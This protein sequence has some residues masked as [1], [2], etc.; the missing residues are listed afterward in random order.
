MVETI[1][2]KNGNFP[3]C[4]WAW[5]ST[6]GWKVSSNPT[7][8]TC[9]NCKR[10]GVYKDALKTTPVKTTISNTTTEEQTKEETNMSTVAYNV[11][12]NTLT[13]LINGKLYSMNTSCPE[14]QNAYD[15][16][17]ETPVDAEALLRVF[18][19]VHAVAGY[20]EGDVKVEGNTITYKGRAI[21]NELT[22]KIIKFMDEG[23]PFKPL[24]KFMERLMKNP[25]KRSVDQLYPFMQHVG[26]QISSEGMLIAYKGVDANLKDVHTHSVDNSPGTTPPPFNRNEVDDDPNVGCS[27]GYHVGSWEYASGFGSRTMRVEVDP[28][29]VVAIPH[30]CNH[31]KVRCT[32][33]K[34]LDEVNVSDMDI[35]SVSVY[36][37]DL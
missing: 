15:I 23:A 2:F 27:Y 9:G 12:G 36:A 37:A 10:T 25:S 11:V 34:V 30:D 18:N 22:D 7:D 16:L 24:L 26:L 20:C 19:K 17:N 6:L 4:D 35:D 5:S 3:A 14:I 13:C 32:E 31:Q 21:R 28:G 33:Y 29:V 8:V 1:H